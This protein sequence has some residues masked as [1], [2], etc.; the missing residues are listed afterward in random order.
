MRRF[1]GFILDIAYNITLML[2]GAFMYTHCGKHFY[3]HYWLMII[4][5]SIIIG[6]FASIK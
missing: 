1:L 5:C 4:G 6:I 2:M 3:N